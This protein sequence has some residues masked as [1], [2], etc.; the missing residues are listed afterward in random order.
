MLIGEKIGCT[1]YV[2]FRLDFIQTDRCPL[3]F[4]NALKLEM[5]EPG[6]SYGIGR[7]KSC[8]VVESCEF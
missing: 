7:S 5:P 4:T 3:Q 8:I 6:E 1:F 2:I